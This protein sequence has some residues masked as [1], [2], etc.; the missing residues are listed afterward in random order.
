[1]AAS[2]PDPSAPSRLDATIIGRVQGVGFRYFVLREAAALDLT[3][4]VANSPDGNV[5]C[6]AEG[7]RP[8][9]EA[10]LAVLHRGPGSAIVERVSLA[11]MPAAG[12]FTT[13]EVRS[14]AHRGD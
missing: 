14:G 13:F 5:R 12:S 9:L 2:E 8:K 3:G 4:W 1:M 7:E 11:W 6:V 10:L